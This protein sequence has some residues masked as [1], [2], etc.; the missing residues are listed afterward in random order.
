MHVISVAIV[1]QLTHAFY[2]AM[3]RPDT[4]SKVKDQNLYESINNIEHRQS[5]YLKL[6]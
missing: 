3:T 2:F 1:S 4:S 6:S 5:N